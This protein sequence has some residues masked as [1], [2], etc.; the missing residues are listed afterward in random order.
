MNKKQILNRI[1]KTDKN[2]TE[3]LVPLIEIMSQANQHYTQ[4]INSY[5]EKIKKLEKEIQEN[6][7][8]IF[9]YKQNQ[10]FRNDILNTTNAE[11]SIA[12]ITQTNSSQQMVKDVD[13]NIS[14]V[15]GDINIDFGTKE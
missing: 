13:K 1:K 15:S 11:Q 7:K 10:N 12:N 5:K 6:E 8:I 2:N 14:T 9:A 3:L 4:E